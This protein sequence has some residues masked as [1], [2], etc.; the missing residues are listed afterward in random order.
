MELPSLQM[1]KRHLDLT[2][3][4]MVQWFR[5]YSAGVGRTNDAPL[6]RA[7]SHP[8][9]PTSCWKARSGTTIPP[10]QHF[11]FLK[12]SESPVELQMPQAAPQAAMPGSGMLAQAVGAL[13][14]HHPRSWVLK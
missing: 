10:V 4:D 5:G 6:Y 7:M 13:T 3:G 1:F 8:Q 14:E 11:S 12:C 2:L 9:L